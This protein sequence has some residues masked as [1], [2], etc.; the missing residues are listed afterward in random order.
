MYRRMA[1]AIGLS[2]ASNMMRSAPDPKPAKSGAI[3]TSRLVVSSGAIID[4]VP[5][6][7]IPRSL[8][9]RLTSSPAPAASAT[10]CRSAESAPASGLRASPKTAAL[11]Q[12][13]AQTRTA[14]SKPQ[15]PQS[16]LCALLRGLLHW[17]P[18]PWG[19]QKHYCRSR[20]SL[21]SRL[22]QSTSCRSTM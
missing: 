5:A 9:Y 2:A 7:V 12:Y 4:S 15:R 13:H 10:D 6:E 22:G 8:R 11:S 17:G 14:N 16:R 19:K 18:P 21:V 3:I 20:C 1:E